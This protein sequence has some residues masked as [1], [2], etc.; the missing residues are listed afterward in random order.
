MNRK[1]VEIHSIHCVEMFSLCKHII[2]DVAECGVGSGLTTF[3]LDLHVLQAEKNL[4][5]FDTFTGLPYDDTLESKE[6]CKQGEFGNDGELFLEEFEGIVET[7][8]IPIPG[9]LEETLNGFENNKFCFVWI[10][11]D[12]YKS[13]LFAYRFFEDRMSEGGIIGFHDYNFYRCPGVK[14]VV[15]EEVDFNKYQLIKNED[16]CYFIRRKN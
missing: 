7:A 14:K 9:L 2:G 3:S 6:P 4:F 16:T 5:A 13:T 15:D 11:L 12:L 1:P 8:I 10:D